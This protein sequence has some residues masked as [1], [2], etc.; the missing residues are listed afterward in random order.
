MTPYSTDRDTTLIAAKGSNIQTAELHFLKISTPEYKNS[1][2]V[3][4]TTSATDAT[5]A[6]CVVKAGT[7]DAAAIKRVIANRVRT[8]K[9]VVATNAAVHAGAAECIVRHAKRV[10]MYINSS[11]PVNHWTAVYIDCRAAEG[12]VCNAAGR[13]T[14]TVAE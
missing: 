9:H 7:T 12:V 5:T 11:N 6:K 10:S 2:V 14:N 13:T 4:N 1:S 3:E 8:A